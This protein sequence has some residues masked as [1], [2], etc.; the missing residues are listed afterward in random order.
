M[1]VIV[2][3]GISSAPLWCGRLPDQLE[4]VISSQE[5]AQVRKVWTPLA[6]S[7]AASPRAPGHP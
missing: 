5:R 4:L 6:P 1:Q 2:R 7:E 3:D